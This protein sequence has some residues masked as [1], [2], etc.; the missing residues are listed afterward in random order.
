MYYLFFSIIEIGC[1]AFIIWYAWNW[2][3]IE[4]G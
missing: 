2:R 3:N 1:T 4:A